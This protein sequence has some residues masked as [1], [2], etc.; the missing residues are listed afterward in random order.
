M[1]PLES[2][3][4][5][6]WRNDTSAVGIPAGRGSCVRVLCVCVLVCVC[7]CVCEFVGREVPI[8]KRQCSGKSCGEGVAGQRCCREVPIKKCQWESLRK[9]GCWSGVLAERSQQLNIHT[10]GL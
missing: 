10:S 9:G 8:R 5:F 3:P 4:P 6:Q 7:A 2:P 1:R